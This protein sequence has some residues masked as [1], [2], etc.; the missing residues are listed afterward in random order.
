MPGNYRSVPGKLNVAVSAVITVFAVFGVFG[1]FSH[2]APR[3]CCDSFGEDC[4]ESIGSGRACRVL[5]FLL[6]EGAVQLS[7]VNPTVAA[8]LRVLRGRAATVWGG[9]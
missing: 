9:L 4:G 8:Y 5:L 7:E 3:K 2:L 1:R 6:L